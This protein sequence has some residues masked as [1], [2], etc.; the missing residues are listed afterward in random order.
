[1]YYKKDIYNFKQFF[2]ILGKKIGD[3]TVN[4]IRAIGYDTSG[5]I[6][7]KTDIKEDYKVLPQRVNKISEFCKPNI[8]HPERIKISKKKWQHLQDLK[9]LLPSDCHYFYDNIP[10][11]H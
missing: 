9:S 4:M 11:E 1:M 6:Y 8:L 2:K 5:T 3:P 10:F 7:F